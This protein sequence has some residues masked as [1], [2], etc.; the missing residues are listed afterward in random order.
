[1]GC[2]SKCGSKLRIREYPCPDCNGSG[3]TRDLYKMWQYSC[4]CNNYVQEENESPNKEVYCNRCGKKITN[5]NKR[6]EGCHRCG[7]T[8]FRGSYYGEVK[9]NHITEYSCS[10]CGFKC[11]IPS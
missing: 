5:P 10:N 8:R 7:S 6:M 4:D 3:F 11:V 2:C 1:M 9:E